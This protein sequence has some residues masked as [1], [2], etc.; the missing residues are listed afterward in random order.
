[1]SGIHQV[2]LAAA[3]TSGPMNPG[4]HVDI[5]RTATTDGVISVGIG[6]QPDGRTILT[7][8]SPP[9]N[10]YVPTTAGIGAQ[11]WARM[12]IDSSVSNT[13]FTNNVPNAWFPCNGAYWGLSNTPASALATGSFRVEFA[14]DAAGTNIVARFPGGVTWRIG[15]T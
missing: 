14:T 4:F 6:L 12:Q 10:W 2:L 15:K 5:V 9:P 11:Y 7:P 13:Q 8:G 3:S 1:M